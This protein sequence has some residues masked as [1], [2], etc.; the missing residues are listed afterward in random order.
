[1]YQHLEKVSYTHVPKC[2][3]EFLTFTSGLDTNQANGLVANKII[4]GSDGVTSASYTS[5]HSIRQF[6]PDFEELRLDLA[7]NDPL[8]VSHNGRERMRP[9]CGPNQVMRGR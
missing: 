4:E 3:N 7:T 6:P 5:N 8:K 9:N 2:R 1:V